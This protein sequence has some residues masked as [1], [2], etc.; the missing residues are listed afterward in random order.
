MSLPAN[1]MQWHIGLVGYGEVGRILAEDLPYLP[2]WH[3]RNV[4]IVSNR[5]GGFT[6]DTLASFRALES[7]YL[8]EAR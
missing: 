5:V 1:V 6:L 4:A 8:E 2:L 3:E 7:A